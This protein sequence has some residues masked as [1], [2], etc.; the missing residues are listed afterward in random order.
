MR[1][2]DAMHEKFAQARAVGNNQTASAKMAGCLPAVAANQGCRMERRPEIQA[3]ISELQENA[4]GPASDVVVLAPG[5]TEAGMEVVPRSWIISNSV[6]VV[7]LALEWGELAN[8]IKALD[9]LAR[10]EGHIVK[11]S[12]NVRE[13]VNLNISTMG[14][15]ELAQTLKRA[16]AELPAADR[17]RL[18]L[19]APD[20]QDLL[21]QQDDQ[22]PN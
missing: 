22:K 18:L 8:A 3:R 2:D 10:L 14:H 21:L 4:K 15:R 9:L 17:A 1:L 6:K 13:S 20:M 7:N 16:I 19:E 11:E 12:H 5:T